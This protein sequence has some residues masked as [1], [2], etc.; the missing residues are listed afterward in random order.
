MV[1]EVLIAPAGIQAEGAA[2]APPQAAACSEFRILALEAPTR[3][4]HLAGVHQ[5]RTPS[6]GLDRELEVAAG[7]DAQRAQLENIVT[8]ETVE[9][10][11]EPPA[12]LA[13]SWSH[14]CREIRN[15][16]RAHLEGGDRK[17]A[18]AELADLESVVPVLRQACAL[19]AHSSQ[20]STFG[21]VFVAGDLTRCDG[22]E[23]CALSYVAISRASTAAHVL[24]WPGSTS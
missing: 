20:G 1:G 7:T 23:S 4:E 16:I 17:K 5:W 13:E 10:W 24:P 2:L 15:S 6:R 3:L 14:Q 8:G 19:T 21:E 18:L 12:G 9:T 11:L 22:Q